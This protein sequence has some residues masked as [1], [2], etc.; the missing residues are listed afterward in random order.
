MLAKGKMRERRL[1]SV[2]INKNLSSVQGLLQWFAPKVQAGDDVFA[3]FIFISVQNLD[4]A[5]SRIP[6][7]SNQVDGDLPLV[8]K[9][10][11]CVY[12]LP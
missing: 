11:T 10:A 2:P 5:I 12:S 1:G 8:S 7:V 3:A 6:V 9:N 4:L